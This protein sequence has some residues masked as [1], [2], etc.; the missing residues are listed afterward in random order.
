MVTRHSALYEGWLATV[1]MHRAETALVDIASGEKWTFA[2]LDKAVASVADGGHKIAFP[3]GNSANFLFE[4]LRAWRQGKITCPLES[5]QARPVTSDDLADFPRQEKGV[6]TVHL[7]VS[8]ASTGSAK[9]ILFNAAQLAADARNIVSSMGLR[10]DWPNVAVIS[11]AHSY[12]FSNLVLPLILY[13]IPLIIAPAPLPEVV[14]HAARYF[15]GITLPAVPALW[16]AWLNSGTIPRN[17]R[18]AISAGAPLPRDLESSI[19]ERHNL[20]LHNFYGSSECGGIAYDRSTE[21]RNDDSF[22]GTAMD[23]VS[24][25]ISANRTLVVE[26]DAVGGTYWPEPRSS[27][28]GRRFETTDLAELDGGAVFLR[29]RVS[30]IINVAGR[31]ISPESIEQILRGHPAV[32]ECVVFGIPAPEERVE[33]ISACV[34]GSTDATALINFL[35]NYLPGWQIPRRWWFT[36]ELLAN[37]RGKISRVEWREKFLRQS[38]G[39]T[40]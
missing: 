37:G 36:P 18:L 23:N 29:G 31:K 35:S 19:F 39:D 12:G 5:G 25:S 34:N 4:I 28:S 20:K 33:V 9:C 1:Q 17:V 24:L 26:G 27:L 13:G 3:C 10:A 30:D 21:P 14:V 8:S 16:K 15:P 6:D 22:A 11:M 38:G 2:Q 40:R 32:R 7:K